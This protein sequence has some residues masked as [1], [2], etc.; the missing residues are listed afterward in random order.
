MD[1]WLVRWMEG[2]MDG[3]LVRRMEGQMDGW[4]D[5]WMNGCPQLHDDVKFGELSGALQE[6][7]VQCLKGVQPHSLWTP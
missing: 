1:G 4:R 2:Q 5:R 6:N 7:V 3:W